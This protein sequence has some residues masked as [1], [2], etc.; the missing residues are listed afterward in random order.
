MKTIKIN[1]LLSLLLLPLTSC[2]NNEITI[3]RAKTIL[4]DIKCYQ[5]QNIET[6]QKKTY[7]TYF[8][9][10]IVYEDAVKITK[11]EYKR[12]NTS[13][14]SYDRI[15]GK[16]G[17]GGKKVKTYYFQNGDKYYNYDII[18]SSKQEVPKIYYD[19]QAKV[20]YITEYNKRYLYKLLDISENYTDNMKFYSNKAGHLLAKYQPKK[21]TP[22]GKLNTDIPWEIEFKD[23]LFVKFRKSEGV[24]ENREGV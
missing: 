10:K 1:I 6:I 11:N 14:Y 3:D 12:N 16:G 5:Q 4:D 9:E 8:Y 19:I 7:K 20:N 18:L 23:K 24:F 17:I 13:I 21:Y 22:D 15:K 2:S